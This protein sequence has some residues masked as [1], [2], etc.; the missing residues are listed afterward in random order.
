M[1]PIKEVENCLRISLEKICSQ[2]KEKINLICKKDKFPPEDVIQE[3]NDYPGNLTFP[4][5][6][7]ISKENIMSINDKEYLVYF[8]LWFNHQESDLILTLRIFKT[9]KGL[10]FYL[11]EVHVH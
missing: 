6:I 10:N 11:E 2:Q 4:L 1:I 9:D 5:N 8:P 3:I 7:D